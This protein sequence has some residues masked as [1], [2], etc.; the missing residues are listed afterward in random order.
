MAAITGSM[1]EDGLADTADGFGGGATREE[2]LALM[3][4]SRLGTFGGLALTFA[5]LLKAGALGAIGASP[6]HSALAIVCTAALSRALTFWHWI[7]TSPARNEGMAYSAGRPDA[8]SLAVGAVV[9]AAA[10]ILL[11]VFFGGAALLA[12]LL[13]ALGVGLF[14]RLAE[15]EIGGHTGDTIGAAQQVAEALIFAGLSSAA[16]ALA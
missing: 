4:D 10:A 3:R 11:L 8:E 5:V 16:T 2:K 6:W 9:G 14:S 1:H 7:T 15:R 12:L 13:A